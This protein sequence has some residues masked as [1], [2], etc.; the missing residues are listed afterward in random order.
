VKNSLARDDLPSLTYSIETVA[1]ETKLGIADTGRFAFTGESDRSVADLLRE[2]RGDA[3]DP[4]ERRDAASWI[5]AYLAEAG[6]TAQVKDVLAA[7]R[8]PA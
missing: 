2:S 7:C 6:G 8:L 3:G 1:I 4:E 5:K